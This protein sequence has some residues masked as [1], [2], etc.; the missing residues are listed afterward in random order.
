VRIG[1]TGSLS[2]IDL[3]KSEFLKLI[4]SFF[5]FFGAKIEISGTKRVEKTPTYL[6]IFFKNI[7]LSGKNRKK[8]KKNPIPKSRRHFNPNI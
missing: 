8:N 5:H 2:S 6:Y 4:T 3:Q 7:S 1:L